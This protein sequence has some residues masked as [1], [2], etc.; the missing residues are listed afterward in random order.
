MINTRKS[1]SCCFDWHLRCI[2]LDAMLYLLLL[3]IATVTR[4]QSWGCEAYAVAVVTSRSQRTVFVSGQPLYA[5]V[6][7]FFGTS[8]SSCEPCDQSNVNFY[9]LIY[10][11]IKI[12][13]L[14]FCPVRLE[15]RK[16]VLIRSTK[17]W[18]KMK[19]MLLNRSILI[20]WMLVR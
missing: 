11:L 20:Q 6:G 13:Q 18:L 9:L 4:H 12:H 14:F 5:A 2:T 16:I 17:L 10:L 15:T 8:V 19:L 7:I 3:L 1:T